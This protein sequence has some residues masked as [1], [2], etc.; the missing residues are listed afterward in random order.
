[1]VLKENMIL[2]GSGSSYKVKKLIDQGGMSTV[3]LAKEVRTDQKVAIKLAKNWE[4]AIKKIIFERDLMKSLSHIHLVNY[5]DSGFYGN[6]PFIVMEY[7]KGVNLEKLAAAKPLDEKEAKIR[8]IQL[9][10]AVDYL[11]SMN[12]IHRDIKPKNVVLRDI[13]YLKLLDLGTAA[14]YNNTGIGEAIISPG[15]YT[16]PE[17]YR[18]TYSIQGDIWS[19][20]A[21][22]FYMVTGQHPII[23]MPGY[24]HNIPSSPP[25]PRK[26]NKDISEDLARVIMRAMR[27]NPSE[28]FSSAQEMLSTLKGKELLVYAPHI[29]ISNSIVKLDYP[30]IIIGRYN[31]SCKIDTRVY[32]QRVYTWTEGDIK[33]IGIVDPQ[34]YIGRK[35]AEIYE[36]GGK[37]YIRDLGSLNKTAIIREKKSR[38][39]VV[40][41]ARK[42]ISLSVQLKDGDIIALAY[43]EKLGPYFTFTFKEG[44]T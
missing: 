19:V 1:M 10:L 37:W 35:H 9:L 34:C 20:A 23:L 40:W 26:L 5:Y 29:V 15:G 7:A 14:F 39:I 13:E 33:R 11:H 17:Q 42:Q 28:R 38:I 27:K 43:D 6:L 3:W 16:P 22:L 12:I 24:P 36:A 8:A 30:R 25:D 32:K 4:I 31:P 2:I 41:K 21:T 18:F 44:S